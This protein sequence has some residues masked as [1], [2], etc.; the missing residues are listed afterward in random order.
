[1][2]SHRFA[3]LANDGFAQLQLLGEIP[4]D[5]ELADEIQLRTALGWMFTLGEHDRIMAPMVEV[6]GAWELQGS[7]TAKWDI[8]PQ[9]QIPLN[10]RQHVRLNLGARI[11]MSD[12]DTRPTSVWAVVCCGTG[13]TADSSRTGRSARVGSASRSMVRAEASCPETGSLVRGTTPRARAECD[14]SAR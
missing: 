9:I 4:F 12:T 5:R 1:M 8:A 14:R 10:R 2:M 3:H 11:P 13:T 7:D 6:I